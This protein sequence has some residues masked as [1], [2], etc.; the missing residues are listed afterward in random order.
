MKAAA[1][2]ARNER[3]DGRSL[4]LAIAFNMQLTPDAFTLEG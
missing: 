1:L 4:K 3:A 2:H